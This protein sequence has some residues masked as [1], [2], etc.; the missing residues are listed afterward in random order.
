MQWYEK[1]EKNNEPLEIPRRLGMHE[2]TLQGIAEQRMV[3]PYSQWM[4]QRPLDFYQSLSTEDKK[5]IESFLNEI[6]GSQAMNFII[7]TKVSRINN[8]F[9]MV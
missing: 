7:K 3:L 6:N 5:K 1:Q 2:F 8:K 4:M 9:M